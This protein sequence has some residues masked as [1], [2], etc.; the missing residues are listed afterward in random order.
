MTTEKKRSTRVSAQLVK[1]LSW[2]VARE[3]RDPRVRSVVLTRVEMTDDL[4]LAKVYLRLLEGGDDQETRSAAVKG[5][6]SAAGVLRKAA[7]LRLGLR[8]VPELRFFYDDR[9]D[10]LGRIEALIAEVH[11]DDK[12]RGT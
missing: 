9:Q 2:L 10:K 7:A 8:F 4:R 5:L 12:K 6:A 3:L 11:Q 1:E